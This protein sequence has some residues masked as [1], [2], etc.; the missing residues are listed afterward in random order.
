[1]T[2]IF[3]DKGLAFLAD[4]AMDVVSIQECFIP[5]ALE[6]YMKTWGKSLPAEDPFIQ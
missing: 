1:M 2:Y 6:D 5:M 4:Q 3:P